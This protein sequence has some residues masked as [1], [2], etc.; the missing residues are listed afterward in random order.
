VWPAPRS[1]SARMFGCARGIEG[2]AL[3][4]GDLVH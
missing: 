4:A 2:C 1:G 3:V